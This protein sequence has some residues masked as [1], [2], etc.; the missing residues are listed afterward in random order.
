MAQRYKV[1]INGIPVILSN[2]EDVP[3]HE[4]GTLMMRHD[5]MPSLAL[6]IALVEQHPGS[7]QS[8]WLVNP[9]PEALWNDFVS[10][11]TLVE[12]AGGR[13]HNNQGEPLLILRNGIWDLPKGHVEKNESIDQAAVREVEEECGTAQLHIEKPLTPTFHTY[14]QKGKRIL[15]KTHWFVMRCDDKRPLA[16]QTEEGITEVCWADRKKLAEA[17]QNMYPSI[18]EV[19]AS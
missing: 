11:H 8:V 16:P 7:L 14:L 17:M 12:A 10:L 13:V 2:G 3:Q 18:L 15:K 9:D 19:L 6:L 4:D 5:D 1:F